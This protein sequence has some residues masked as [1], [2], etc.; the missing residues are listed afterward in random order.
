MSKNI[1]IFGIIS[2]F[3]FSALAPMTFGDYIRTKDNENMVE[4]DKFDSYHILKSQMQHILKR[5]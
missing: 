2:L 5:N 1:L 3:L 4:R